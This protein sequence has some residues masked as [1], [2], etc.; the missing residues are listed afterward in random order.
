MFSTSRYSNLSSR[1]EYQRCPNLFSACPI[2]L[3]P[4][5]RG[6]LCLCTAVFTRNR[7]MQRSNVTSKL[8]VNQG[9]P[10]WFAVGADITVTTVKSPRCHGLLSTP[11]FAPLPLPLLPP[12]GSRY[13]FFDLVN[14][15]NCT[16]YIRSYNPFLSVR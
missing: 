16:L 7:W 10:R 12:Y 8:V 14:S 9:E 6:L 1:L 13:L 2:R 3:I 4:V 11:T 15:S 5:A